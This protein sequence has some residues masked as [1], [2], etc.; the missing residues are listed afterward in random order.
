MPI[1]TWAFQLALSLIRQG[2][3][4][5][6]AFR[7]A[8]DYLSESKM[9]RGTFMA[10]L[11]AERKKEKFV[12]TRQ[13]IKSGTLKPGTKEARTI[14]IG[15]EKKFYTI[16]TNLPAFLITPIVTETF[17]RWMR[18]GMG[19]SSLG[20]R[21]LKH[22]SGRYAASLKTE[23]ASDNFFTIYSD[24]PYADVLETGRK[25]YNL[26]WKDSKIIPI[27]KNSLVKMDK[28]PLV[29]TSIRSLTGKKLRLRPPSYSARM[30]R[31]IYDNRY[32]NSDFRSVAK[33]DQWKIDSK[34]P[35]KIYSPALHLYELMQKKVK[36]VS[37]GL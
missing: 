31:Q 6:E 21:R 9:N 30:A 18:F 37:R 3:I 1:N 14:R 12:S 17:I 27:G 16:T 29:A 10:L 35:M 2:T 20:G 15:T 13:A 32:S 7:Y 8:S 36:S 24:S 19:Q 26:T 34:Y 25:P 28:S 4:P 11:S 23:Q 33:G 5:S 22:P